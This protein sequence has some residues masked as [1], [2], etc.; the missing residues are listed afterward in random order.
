MTTL[1]TLVGEQPIPNLLPIRHIKPERV[2]FV[3][4][5]SG[6]RGTEPVARHVARLVCEYDPDFVVVDPYDLLAARKQIAAKLSPDES[7]MVNITGGTKMMALAAY[8]LA[9]ERNASFIYLQTEGKPPRQNESLLFYYHFEQS[10][11][12]LGKQEILPTLIS[13]RDYLLA[14]LPD[15]KEQGFSHD[16][17]GLSEGGRF[18][19]AIYDALLRMASERRIDLELLPGIHPTEVSDILDIDLVV[20]SGNQVGVIE[21]KKGPNKGKHAIDQLTTIARREYL[22]TYTERF[23]VLGGSVL[24]DHKLLFE[25]SKISVAEIENYQ[26]GQPLSP[27]DCTRLWNIL[28]TQIPLVSLPELS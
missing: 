11:P 3:H 19:K 26:D 17:N 15:Y 28:A 23:V 10:A 24:P 25:N 4:T 18:E 2:L 6:S 12:R 20:R 8:A 27:D 21:I 1:I 5:G 16:R 7:I 9:V 22:G 13:A 14:H